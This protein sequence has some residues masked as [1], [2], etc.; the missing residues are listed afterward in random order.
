MTARVKG[1]RGTGGGRGNGS[2]PRRFEGGGGMRPCRRPP[3]AGRDTR[4]RF[5]SFFGSASW[6]PTRTCFPAPLSQVTNRRPSLGPRH[7]WRHCPVFGPSIG[8][9]AIGRGGRCRHRERR[10]WPFAS[11][12]H[13]R[14]VLVRSDWLALTATLV[15]PRAGRSGAGRGGRLLYNAAGK[16]LASVQA[17]LI[18]QK[19]SI[20]KQ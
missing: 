20:C 6:P 13:R 11:R 15:V 1:W 17:W 8:R 2:L 4:A 19:Q 10:G 7:R 12:R 5:P 14:H 3:R 9:T 18:Q 16:C